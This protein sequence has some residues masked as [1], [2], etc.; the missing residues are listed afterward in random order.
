VLVKELVNLVGIYPVGTCL[1]LDTKEVAIVQSRN[2]EPDLLSRPL[3]RIALST[4]GEIVKPAPLV[5]LAEKAAGGR[6]K[7][8]IVQV[9]DPSKLGITPGDFLIGQT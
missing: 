9:A 7:R 8:S 3:V 4:E 2:P 1:I 5:D 6:F